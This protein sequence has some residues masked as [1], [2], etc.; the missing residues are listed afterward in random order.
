MPTESWALILPRKT[1]TLDVAL[2]GRLTTGI[3]SIMHNVREKVVLPMSL[4]YS[5]LRVPYVTT[6]KVRVGEIDCNNHEGRNRWSKVEGIYAR[7]H[8]NCLQARPNRSLYPLLQ[9]LMVNFLVWFK[10][11]ST[12]NEDYTYRKTC[13]LLLPFWSSSSVLKYTYG[14]RIEHFFIF[15]PSFVKVVVKIGNVFGV[16]L[17]VHDRGL[18]VR[19]MVMLS[20]CRRSPWRDYKSRSQGCCEREYRE[21]KDLKEGNEGIRGLKM[22]G[23]ITIC[24]GPLERC[25]TREWNSK[26]IIWETVWGLERYILFGVPLR[27]SSGWQE[28]VF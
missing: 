20:W 24:P 14:A 18:L 4:V 13:F 27:M 21:A 7:H 17:E 10:N 23:L 22:S 2:T 26:E 16:F 1:S 6:I 11:T 28:L 15:L 19:K 3:Q 8:K 25:S 9:S 5:G 12:L